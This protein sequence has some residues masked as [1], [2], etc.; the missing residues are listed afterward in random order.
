M[1]KVK[2]R[3]G[4]RAKKSGKPAAKRKPAATVSAPG[5]RPIVIPGAWPFPMGSKS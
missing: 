3:V 5:Q 1:A 4:K 2:K